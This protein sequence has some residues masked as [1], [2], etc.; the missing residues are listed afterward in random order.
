MNTD[1]AQEKPKGSAAPYFTVRT[2]A[3]GIVDQLANQLRTLHTVGIMCGYEYVHDPPSFQRSW[4]PRVYQLQSA[5]NKAERLLFLQCGGPRIPAYRVIAK[6]QRALSRVEEF[7]A[8]LFHE[9][10]AVSRFLGFD[11]FDNLIT[12]KRFSTYTVIDVP[13]DKILTSRAISDIPQLRA[14]IG[15]LSTSKSVI[16]AFQQTLYTIPSSPQSVAGSVG[17]GHRKLQ[18]PWLPRTILGG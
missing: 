8:A 13:F 9:A 14:A 1:N 16:Y 3:S 11:K 6:V 15:D 5:L 17:R 10:R 7:S 18:L 2:T 4:H 12:D